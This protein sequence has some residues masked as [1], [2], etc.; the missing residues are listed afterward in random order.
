MKYNQG[1]IL[2]IEENNYTIQHKCNT[3]TGS[4]GCPIINLSNFK[5]IGI[6][7]GT[8]KLSKCNFGTL[9]REPLNLF[10]K[11]LQFQKKMI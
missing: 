9:L 11:I 4:S 6:H 5:V 1:T 3:K 8:R 2:V 10:K 7:K